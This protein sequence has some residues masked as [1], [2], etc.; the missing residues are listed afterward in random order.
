[1]HVDIGCL[2]DKSSMQSHL[3][4]FRYASS[5]LHSIKVLFDVCFSRHV[6]NISQWFST[7]TMK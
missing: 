6:I 4:S 1:M 5:V 3:N 7:Q 2:N